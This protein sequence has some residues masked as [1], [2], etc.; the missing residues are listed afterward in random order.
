M[1]EVSES[2]LS[3]I[4]NLVYEGKPVKEVPEQV[5]ADVQFLSGGSSRVVYELG[6]IVIKIAYR[7]S[8]RR[9]KMEI[10]NWLFAKQNGYEDCFAEVL[11]YS[12]NYS[13]I[14]MRKVNTSS[15]DEQEVVQLVERLAEYGLHVPDLNR[16]DI[17]KVGDTVV[18]MDYDYPVEEDDSLTVDEIMS[19]LE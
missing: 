2:V 11:Q 8:R 12:E 9:N 17:G 5:S 4:A 1:T 7:G 13:W 19:V 18:L 6:E 14:K 15:V 16:R 10:E 3:K